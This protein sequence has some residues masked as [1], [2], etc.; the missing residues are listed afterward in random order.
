[1]NDWFVEF[2]VRESD[3][4]RT[5]VDPVVPIQ[6]DFIPETNFFGPFHCE[7]CAKTIGNFG[8]TEEQAWDINHGTEEE[9]FWA[10]FGG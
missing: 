6:L 8:K 3:D 7:K 4:L 1:M 10:F 2:K 9:Q 5:V